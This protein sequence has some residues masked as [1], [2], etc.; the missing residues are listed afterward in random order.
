MHRSSSVT[1]QSLD[2]L[3]VKYAE[4]PSSVPVASIDGWPLT[5]RSP[6]ETIDAILARAQ[7]GQSFTVNTLNLDH[8]VKLRRDPNFRAA[9]LNATIVTPDGAPIV[10]LAR[11][12]GAI[13]KRTTGADLVIPLLK[14]AARHQLPVYLFGTSAE[15][16]TA[17]TRVLRNLTGDTLNICGAV[18]PPQDFDVSGLAADEAIATIRA[19]GARIVL[20]A[21]GA[22]KQEIFAAR[23][24]AANI[25]AGMISVGAALD[26]IVGAQ[27]RA[28]VMF[29]NYGLEWAWRLATNPRRLGLRYAQCAIVLVDLVVLQPLRNK[30]ASRKPS[31]VRKQ[32]D[33]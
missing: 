13:V 19:T 29:Q 22:P 9:Y 5:T 4:G 26:F 30:F 2:P 15:V 33:L 27:T 25:G 1:S 3:A 14:E 16:L 24:L 6:A 23:A 21:L 32:K 31:Q 12:Q 8:L 7:L 11:Q 28:P 10:W 17:C 20:V 18:A